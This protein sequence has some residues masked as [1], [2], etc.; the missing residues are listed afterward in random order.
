MRLS[1]FDPGI[2]HTASPQVGCEIRADYIADV[3]SAVHAH[4]IEMLDDMRGHINVDADKLESS[5]DQLNDI[6]ADIVGS[7]TARLEADRS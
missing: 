5:L 2:I 7:V 3:L 1:G 6:A 4:L